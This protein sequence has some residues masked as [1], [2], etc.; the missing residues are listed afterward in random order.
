VRSR[1]RPRFPGPTRCPY[2]VGCSGCEH[3]LARRSGIA[4]RPH[5]RSS[6]DGR[7]GPIELSNVRT[8]TKRLTIPQGL[9]SC[10]RDRSAAVPW[11]LLSIS[12]VAILCGML[13]P[14]VVASA[15]SAPTVTYTVHAGSYENTVRLGPSSLIASPRVVAG[16]DPAQPSLEDVYVLG[17][18]ATG[19]SPCSSLVVY[20]S[21]DNGSSFGSPAI[22]S[23]C[24]AGNQVDALV[25]P[26]G[27]LLVA[28]SGPQVVRSFN[29][30]ISWTAAATIDR[31]TTAPALA[32]DPQT[33]DLF[34]AWT[35]GAPGPL[36]VAISQDNGTTWS[37]PHAIDSAGVGAETPQVDAHAG[38]VVVGF[39]NRSD[40][41][42]SP[43]LATVTSANS[44][45]SWT[46]GP[47]LVPAGSEY[48]IG[49]PSVAA[50]PGGVFA[51]VWYQQNGSTSGGVTL[52]A[53]SENGGVD[54]SSPIEVGATAPPITAASSFG[55]IAV[56]DSYGRLSVAW[57]NYSTSNPLEATLNVATSNVS[58]T[59]FST[60]SFGLRFQGTAF[61]GTQFENLGADGAGRVLLAWDVYGS[62]SSPSF[63]VFFRSVTG[64]ATGG[65]SD[66][67]ATVT[68]ENAIT[69]ATVGR[70]SGSGPPLELPS[71]P[72][73][74]Y[75]VWVNSGSGAIL[76]GTIPVRPWSNT[77]FNVSTA[78]VAPQSTYPFPW[79]LLGEFGGAALLVG[80]LAGVYY[81]RISRE[82]VLQQ[83]VRGLLFEYVR[84]HP[85]ASFSAVRDAVGLQNGTAA[86]HLGVLEKQGMLHS[87]SRG[88]R[89]LYFS[90]GDP[91]LWHDVPLSPL[92]A[93]ILEAVRTTPG[94]GVRDL[95]RVL[96]RGAS[97]VSYNVRVLSRLGLLMTQRSG[98]R[99]RCFSP[100]VP[101]TSK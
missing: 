86:Y 99:V 29:G 83:R 28:A 79:V 81:T 40:G 96:G 62:A 17:L 64:E 57:H 73:G 75:Q 51:L 14:G 47:M 82:T 80:V 70:M 68:V 67:G 37:T 4:A 15:G 10:V 8:R 63:G 72:A 87:E 69:G 43:G 1:H 55:H 31:A 33:G 61:N 92:Q 41:S 97:S 100:P 6:G 34:L 12:L 9:S 48:Q 66:A 22:S 18:N 27:T 78:A 54:W 77:A 59:G 39:L 16:P 23:S 88:R 24:F 19:L 53:T 36:Y 7:P 93:A 38:A 60:V 85:G 101:V 25:L 49:T 26:N 46:G 44:G 76:A 94:M 84:E 89:H 11:T 21:V 2:R 50:S 42:I 56:F 65:L 3:K 90:S 45:G 30:G 13:F 52:V 95:G 58:L 74:S 71:L 35:D 5:A 98:M 20:R 91:T 32:R